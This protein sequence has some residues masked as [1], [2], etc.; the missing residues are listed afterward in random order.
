MEILTCMTSLQFRQNEPVFIPCTFYCIFKRHLIWWVVSIFKYTNGHTRK[1][2]VK[3]SFNNIKLCWSTYQCCTDAASISMRAEQTL[4]F[5]MEH[6]NDGRNDGKGS[7]RSSDF[8]SY[9]EHQFWLSMD[10]AITTIHENQIILRISDLLAACID[11]FEQKA[12]ALHF[13]IFFLHIL[14]Q[15][16]HQ[17]HY[18]EQQQQQLQLKLQLLLPL[19]NGWTLLTQWAL[20]QEERKGSKRMCSD[21]G[22]FGFVF[23]SQTFLRIHTNAFQGALCAM[24]ECSLP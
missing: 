7:A 12:R 20:A 6:N 18:Q 14:Q 4:S 1:K 10:A 24:S 5:W 3:W 19:P 23:F 16:Q 15:H 9:L 21:F 8:V 17:H 2:M 22:I 13:I 11:T